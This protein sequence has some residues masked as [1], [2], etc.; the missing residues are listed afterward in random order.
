MT[1]VQIKARG[2]ANL[3]AFETVTTTVG[4]L[5]ILLWIAPQRESRARDPLAK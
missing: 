3:L 2:L 1:I 4:F 5:K